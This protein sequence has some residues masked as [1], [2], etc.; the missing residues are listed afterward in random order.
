MLSAKHHWYKLLP[1]HLIGIFRCKVLVNGLSF[2]ACSTNARTENFKRNLKT[3]N[4]LGD[5]VR[6]NCPLPEWGNSVFF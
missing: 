4:R 1:E 6:A 2:V 3:C 5:G